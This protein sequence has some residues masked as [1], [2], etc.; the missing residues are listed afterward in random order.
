MKLYDTNNIK[1]GFLDPKNP[2]NDILHSTEH[3]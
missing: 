2:K 3:Q 1:Y